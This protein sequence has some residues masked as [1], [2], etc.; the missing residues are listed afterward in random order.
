M[1]FF[2]GIFFLAL[3]P[4]IA[5]G[6]SLSHYSSKECAGQFEAAGVSK[7][8]AET[9]AHA[10]HSLTVQDLRKFH[11]MATEQNNIPTV[12]LNLEREG[13][14]LSYA[15]DVP[16]PEGFDTEEMRMVD[17]VLSRLGDG[18]DG[19]GSVWSS[20]ER[21]VHTFH[22][23][24]LWA[25]IATQTP[26]VLANVTNL[27]SALCSCITDTEN[28]GVADKVR[29]IANEYQQWMPISLHEWGSKIPKLTDKASW[30]VWKERLT[31]Y[32]GDEDIRDAV[33]Y[34]HC[35]LRKFDSVDVA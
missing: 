1:T 31:F 28:N 35:A 29:W 27:D 6:R 10:V 4:A 13:G 17:L 14:I 16:L 12:N 22:M 2:R 8:Y 24:D 18:T 7:R 30:K 3:V 25:R 11:P 23:R 26:T 21:V 15:P 33:I 9:I 19:L 34:M 5:A 20:L 32:Y